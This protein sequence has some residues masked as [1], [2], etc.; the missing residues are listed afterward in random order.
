M[1]SGGLGLEIASELGKGEFGHE[2]VSRLSNGLPERHR[3]RGWLWH[4]K[5]KAFLKE[6]A[7]G[8][9]GKVLGMAAQEWANESRLNDKSASPPPPAEVSESGISA[10]LTSI[11]FDWEL[12]QFLRKISGP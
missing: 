8:G 6:K 7:L 3:N 1:G 4:Q 2:E 9:C 12:V 11:Q 10:F 5:G